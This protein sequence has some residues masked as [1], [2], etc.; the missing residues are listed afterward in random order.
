MVIAQNHS[1]DGGVIWRNIS[2][3]YQPFITAC[4]PD[5][6]KT[7][8]RTPPLFVD[9]HMQIFLLFISSYMHPVSQYIWSPDSRSSYQYLH[10]WCLWSKFSRLLLHRLY[11]AD[12]AFRAPPVY[13]S[14]PRRTLSSTAEVHL[15]AAGLPEPATSCLPGRMAS[16][17]DASAEVETEPVLPPSRSLYI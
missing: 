9:A 17:P 6:R 10:M 2:L 7:W 11:I 4:K 8:V 12:C 15:L 5:L 16:S 1:D 13:P 3:T 14:S